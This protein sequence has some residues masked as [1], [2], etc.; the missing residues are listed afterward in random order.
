MLAAIDLARRFDCSV[1]AGWRGEDGA[2]NFTDWLSQFRD[3]A[4]SEPASVPI[5]L[6]PLGGSGRGI[7]W[8]ET[9][10]AVLG[11][12]RGLE[13]PICYRVPKTARPPAPV[14]LRH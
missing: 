9:A 10:D 2:A 13:K 4:L 7:R 1:A 14:R 5:A 8:Y 12:V 6:S 3:D 11:Y